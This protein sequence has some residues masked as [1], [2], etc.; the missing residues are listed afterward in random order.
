M[1]AKPVLDSS[2]TNKVI[3][4]PES[5]QLDVLASLCERR[6][7]SVIRI[8]LVSILDT[9]DQAA[10]EVWLRQFIADPPDYFIV[11]T[12][13]GLRRLLSAAER[14][15]LKADFVKALSTTAKIC[16]G[17]KPE[18]V[19]KELGLKSEYFGSEPTTGGIIATL[20]TLDLSNRRLSIQLYGEDPNLR[21]MEYLNSRDVR[22]PSTVAPYIYAPDSDT[23]RVRQLI[24]DM[25]GGE[26]DLIAFTSMPQ[27][28]RLFKVAEE[29]QLTDALNLALS[30]LVVAA[31]GPVVRDLLQ[32][33]GCNV[34]VMPEES[35]FMKPLVRAMEIYFSRSS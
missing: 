22:A 32:E 14:I 19:L 29:A 2:L 35:Y 12:G 1:S 9:P 11:L 24:E 27:V 26:V 33:Y 28:R 5:R 10:V 13:E 7:A 3:A 15:Q 8:P 20:E 34:R 4:L 23:Q 30:N 25:S 16:R 18:R 31:V 21:L 6:Q 17:P